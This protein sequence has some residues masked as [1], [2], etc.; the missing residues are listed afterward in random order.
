MKGVWLASLLASLLLLATPVEA[1]VDLRIPDVL[2][3]DADG[4]VLRIAGEEGPIVFRIQVMN[5]ATANTSL[6]S[7]ARVTVSVNRENANGTA[8]F[9]GTAVV[10]AGLSPGNS[11]TV[12]VTWTGGR[13]SGNYT[14]TAAVEGFPN[15]GFAVT[16]VVAKTP[17][18][19]GALGERILQYSWLW[20]A[21]VLAVVLFGV[22]LAARK[23]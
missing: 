1:A 15:S 18:A 16:F 20:G 22:V 11:T 19:A 8:V 3:L 4:E 7:S 13:T 17:V 23:R 21:F 2:L 5:N 6:A 10:P 12:Q 9:N 14:V